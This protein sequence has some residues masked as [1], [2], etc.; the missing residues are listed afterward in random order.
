MIMVAQLLI[1][2]LL[3]SSDF[4]WSVIEEFTQ[5]SVV[6]AAIMLLAALFSGLL[7]ASIKFQLVYLRLNNTL[8][9]HR[10]LHLAAQDP[11]IDLLALQ[12]KV[13]P[14]VPLN[15]AEAQQNQVWYQHIYYPLQHEPLI[16]DAHKAFLLWRDSVVVSLVIGLL[17]ALGVITVPVV[18]AVFAPYSFLVS[19]FF[20]FA[21]VLAA[22]HSGKRM[23]TNAVVTWLMQPRPNQK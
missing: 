22:H 7:P 16:K 20:V 4:S 6:M 2:Y 9:G 5:G 1:A 19:V 21:S 13:M 12:H 8:P 10:F 3:S 18:A 14:L 11:R 23:V 17:L 15:A